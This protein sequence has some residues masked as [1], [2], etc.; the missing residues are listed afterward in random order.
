MLKK[1]NAFPKGSNSP[2][3]A[4]FIKQGE[5]FAI[6][7]NVRHGVAIVHEPNLPPEIDNDLGRHASKLKNVDLLTVSFEHLMFRIRQPHKGESIFLPVSFESRRP[8]RPDNDDFSAIGC[9][10][11]I[12]IAQLRHVPPAKRSGKSPVENQ[13]NEALVTVVG[14]SYRTAG[15][16]RQFKVWGRRIDFYFYSHFSIKI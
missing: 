6:G 15:K 14:Q 10:T 16:I 2:D 7:R 11:V 1:F 9:K 13:H 3:G 5:Y 8:L 12:F 4:D